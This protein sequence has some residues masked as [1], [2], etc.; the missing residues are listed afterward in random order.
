MT[1]AYEAVEIERDRFGRPL[2]APPTGKGKKVPYRR[3]TTFVGALD[4][5]YQ[6]QQWMKR[7]V[8]LGMGQRSDLVLA[9][10]AADPADK[11]LLNGIAE[12]AHEAAGGSAAATRG[13]ALHSLTERVDR[14]QPLGVVPDEFKADIEAYKRA[15]DGIE[16][17]GIETLRVHD[18]LKVA[19]TPDRIGRF[20]W[21]DRLVIS[22]VKTGSMA[23]YAVPKMAMQLAVYARSV[24]YDIATDKR[25]EDPGE[26]DLNR[27]VIIHLPAG[28][29]RCDLYEIDIAL[30]WGACLIAKQVWT[31][32]GRKGL[33]RPMTLEPPPPPATWESLIA[34][35]DS[36][37]RLREIW[38]RASELGQLSEPLKALAHTRHQ[39]LSA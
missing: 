30:G 37:D 1:I 6:L 20:P 19:G 8:V 10:A 18:D 4:E 7:Q 39:E 25:T 9:A 14:G 38:T 21:S 5:T 26:I 12:Q 15:T 13:T 16:W 31:W 22:D 35:A 29:G 36:V 17:V 23:D 28:Q 32:R 34:N 2:I 24:A 33:T 3:C 11:K 27:G